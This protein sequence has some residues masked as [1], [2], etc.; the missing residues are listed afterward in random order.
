MQGKEEKR[1]FSMLRGVL[2]TKIRFVALATK[3]NKNVK[4][5]L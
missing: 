5:Y 4:K 1:L 3:I 2:K